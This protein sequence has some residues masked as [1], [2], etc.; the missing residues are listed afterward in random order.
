MESD[1]KIKATVNEI[2]NAFNNSDLYSI[3]FYE[4]IQPMPEKYDD[5]KDIFI[6]NAIV[7]H[8]ELP[9]HLTKTVYTLKGLEKAILRL[10]NSSYEVP[11]V[12]IIG[13]LDY[14]IPMFGNRRCMPYGKL[15]VTDGVETKIVP[16]KDGDASV[17][18]QQYFTFNRKRYY[19]RNDGSLHAPRYVVID[20]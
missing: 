19:I 4:P 18:Y 8:E 1:I 5:N 9:K 16:I 17:G 7:R 10:R 14:T 20:D 12:N 2:Y 3:R 15:K 6:F 13:L 11:K